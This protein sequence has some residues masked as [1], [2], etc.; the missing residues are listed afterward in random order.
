[1]DSIDLRLLVGL[2]NPG[3]QYQG[4]RH[5]IGFMAIEKLA[6][7]KFVKFRQSKKLFGHTADI[8]M[9]QNIQRLLK[10]NTFMNESGLSIK[11]T[12]EWFGLTSSQI[13][14][15]VDDMDLPLGKLRLRTKGGSGG[16]KGLAST[17]QHL[18]TDNFCRLRIGIGAPSNN[19]AERKQKT[20]SYVL[21]SFTPKENLIVKNV[22]NEII[23]SFDLIRQEGLEK[24]TNKI[25]SYEN[26]S[27]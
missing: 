23:L 7:K 3:P 19:P 9:G 25:N 10:P 4:T 16:H 24:A 26:E 2:G 27:L 1:M 8:G 20:N 18:G 14:V 11:A 6:E 22:I 12:M 17:I 5:N 21:G 13:I 15:L